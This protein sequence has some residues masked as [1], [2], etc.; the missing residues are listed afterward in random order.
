ML[1]FCEVLQGSLNRDFLGIT[2]SDRYLYLVFSSLPAARPQTN[3]R[4]LQIF[5]DESVSEEDLFGQADLVKLYSALELVA[6]AFISANP[7]L[8]FI[9]YFLQR[10]GVIF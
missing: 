10:C 2:A 9:G 8:G 4:V 7:S 1:T 3:L 6:V 5:G